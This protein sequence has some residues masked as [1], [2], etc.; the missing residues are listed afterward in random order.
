MSY[1]DQHRYYK[2]CQNYGCHSFIC[3][4]LLTRRRSP[5]NRVGVIY[6]TDDDKSRI[7]PLY[8]RYNYNTRRNEYFY[9]VKNKYNDFVFQKVPTKNYIYNGD[10][11]FVEGRRYVVNFY[12][13]KQSGFRQIIYPYYGHG[14][15]RLSYYGD[16]N[17]L[18]L[19]RRHGVLRPKDSP[20]GDFI[21]LF[22][23]TINHRRDINQYYIRDRGQFVKLD[24]DIK[25]VYDGDELTLPTRKGTW[26]FE[27]LEHP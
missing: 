3:Q 27:E 14:Y 10:I 15:P 11:L 8:R 5:L 25:R 21:V 16:K 26:T 12:R 20:D 24:E 1:E 7:H 13:N 17:R 9:K 19:M 23:R 6:S 18:D 4:S 22:Q 2:C